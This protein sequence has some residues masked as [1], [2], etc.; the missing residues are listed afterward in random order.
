MKKYLKQFTVWG[1]GSMRNI[2]KN[3]FVSAR[4]RLTL[5]YTIAT[6][7]IVGLFSVALFFSLQK[8]AQD[9]IDEDTVE[10][11]NLDH[12]Y[13]RNIS[14]VEDTI[15]IVDFALLFIVTGFGYIIAGK[16]LK[17]IKETMESQRRFLADASHDLRTPLAIM[18][19]ESQVLIQG[20]SGNVVEYKKVI[21]SNIEEI[22][23]MARLVEDLLTIARSEANTP[24]SSLEITN[25]KKIVEEQ[26]SKIQVQAEKKNVAVVITEI[27]AVEI[28]GHTHAMERVLQNILQNA[29]NYTFSDGTVSISLT[30]QQDYCTMVIRD[31]GVGISAK[32][33][34]YVFDRFYKAEHSRNDVSGSGLGLP[35]AKQIVEQYGGTIKIDSELKKGTVITILLP[36]IS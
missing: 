17:P 8:N 23:K 34:P 2:L 24:Q 18:K 22:N 31:T 7:V 10:S 21:E 3:Q 33:L 35:I 13:K 36:K 19:S 14:D 16:T 27:V 4:V 26:V 12:I 30:S 5:L 1:I 28:A 20:N 11:P 9:V 32:D 15:V 6:M 29:I 25:L